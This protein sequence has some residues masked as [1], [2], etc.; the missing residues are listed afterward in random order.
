MFKI[1]EIGA[2]NITQSLIDIKDSCTNKGV[3]KLNSF[4]KL[5]ISVA[6]F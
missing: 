5:T 4:K 6:V 3:S 1:F 2:K